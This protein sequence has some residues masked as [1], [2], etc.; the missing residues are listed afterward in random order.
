MIHRRAALLSVAGALARAVAGRAAPG[1]QGPEEGGGQ[2]GGVSRLRRDHGGRPRTARGRRGLRG[3]RGLHP[4]ARVARNW[5]A[6]PTDMVRFLSAVSGTL[7][8]PF[9]S[10]RAYRLMVA[11]P[12]IAAKPDGR[13]VGLGWDTVRNAPGAIASR[14]TAASPASAPGSSTSPTAS[15]GPSCSTRPSPTRTPPSPCPRS[16]AASTRPS[17]PIG[18]GR[19]WICSSGSPRTRSG[20]IPAQIRPRKDFAGKGSLRGPGRPATRKNELPL[21]IDAGGTLFLF[22]AYPYGYGFSNVSYKEALKLRER[23]QAEDSE[24]RIR[25]PR[26]VAMG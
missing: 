18:P 26:V 24:R 12:P 21:G 5:L 20:V 19:R 9:L 14:R 23:R 1:A 8:K 15:T 4:P 17:R 25:G 22:P 2:P 7:G 16:S 11:P 3:P 10:P 13:H 6:T